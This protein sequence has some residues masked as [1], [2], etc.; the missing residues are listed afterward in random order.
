MR[1]LIADDDVDSRMVLQKNLEAAGYVVDA[2]VNGQDALERARKCP[3]D[4]IISDILMPVLD[5]Y[6]F[7]F[8]VKNDKILNRIP[9]V[10]YTAT[11][12]DL[13]DERLAI[14]LGASRYILKPV[15]PDEFLHLIDEVVRE[16]QEQILAVPDEL[17]EDPLN[18]FRMY[19]TSVARKLHEKV[20]E[21]ELYR[22]IFDNSTEAVAI[23]DTAG[24]VLRQNP[25]HGRLLGYTDEELCGRSPT[26][27]LEAKTGAGII[28]GLSRNVIAE[29]EGVAISRGGGRIAVEYTVFP[30]RNEPGNVSARV[31]IL[32]DISKRKEAEKQRQLFRT[33]VDCSNDCIF[34]LDPETGRFIDVNDRACERIG[35]GHADFLRK[36]VGAVDPSMDTMERWQAHVARMKTE[37]TAIFESVHRCA[38]G[39][40][41]PVEVSVVYTE[42]DD[43][44][45]LMAVARDITERQELTAQLLQSQKMEAVGK[46]AG[47]VAHDFN[48][49]LSVILGYT[50]IAQKRFSPSEPVA[51]ELRQVEIA[52]KR[53]AD[54][55]RQLLLF[56]RKEQ[57]L[58]T[59]IDL[60]GAIDELL[61]MLRRV[62]GEDVRL[63]LNFADDCW[64]IEGDAGNIV[65]VVMNLAVNARDSMP[66]GGVL[67]MKTENVVIDEQYC[68]HHP[69]ARPGRFV[70]LTVSDTGVGMSED[71]LTH[72]FEPFYTTKEVG[73][74]TGLGLSVV[75]G[76]VKSHKGWLTV[77]SE[78]GQGANFRL[79]F[80]AVSAMATAKA[81]V[82]PDPEVLQGH[83]EKILV[84]DD[85]EMILQLELS[86]LG[87]NGYVVTG[88]DS[89]EEGLARFAE[90][91]GDFDLVLS[92][93]VLPG[94]N[95]VAFVEKLLEAQPDL[96]VLLCSGYADQKNNWSHNQ[97]RDYA[98]LEKPFTIVK[99]YEAVRGALAQP[100]S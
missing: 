59:P 13:E 95:G 22:L 73:K 47:G 79:Y 6:K 91:G 63:V 33:L 98:F 54:L 46:L 90:Q 85:D 71:L 60:P 61:K 40:E 1:I 100:R 36:Q 92:D 89:A 55:V 31:W 9:F 4:L 70:C 96:H 50:E 75:Y 58:F 86:A 43:G 97:E 80:P 24:C 88:A 38:D 20:R 39:T 18:L 87:R 69:E 82:V 57:Q 56:G 7:C 76:L 49:L 68:R 64:R 32:R 74:G 10:F 65:Q 93:V 45:Y 14:G 30:I 27:Y 78:P 44:D 41:F 83:G 53:A 77:C 48:N 99:F 66:E 34:I 26:V 16:A 28:A 51:E 3:P 2:A 52:G 8:E 42:T 12:V 94:M 37:G 81:E 29:G 72:I 84:V 62:I 15:A 21:L 35:Y 23:V 17:V 19:D 67:R 25:A 11:Y 5:G